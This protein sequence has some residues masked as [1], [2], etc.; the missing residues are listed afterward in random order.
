[1]FYGCVAVSDQNSNVW[2]MLLSLSGGIGKRFDAVI[3]ELLNQT[4]LLQGY[5]KVIIIL[6][7]KSK[8]EHA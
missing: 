1:M 8:Y 6:N 3:S 2:W 4:G 7:H 5:M